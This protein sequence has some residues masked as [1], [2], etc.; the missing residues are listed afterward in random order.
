MTDE[1]NSRVAVVTGAG[2]GI[3]KAV[4]TRML[5]AGYRVVLAGRREEPLRALANGHPNALVLSTDITIAEQV[6]RLFTGA[7][8]RW[9]RLDVLFNNAGVPGPTA[10]VDEIEPEA[11]DAVIALNL[12]AAAMCARAA[13]K[14]MKAQNPRGG[15]IINNGSLAAHAPRPQS[16]AYTTTKHAISGLTKSIELDGRAYGISCGQ[17]DIG[18]TE[19]ELVDRFV[20][21]P[22]A[23]QPDGRRMQEP[24]FPVD[25]AARAVMFMADTP[26]SANVNSV[27]IT[28]AG[29]PFIGR[30]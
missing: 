13:M 30:G 12:T 20:T 15:R 11:W 19:T 3:G 10:S 23:L 16:V 5:G 1:L 24:T 9:G 17:I 25:E 8:D 27:V 7:R 2:S 18:N 28:A 14:V 4:A 21:G 29:M 26:P 6:T 22:G